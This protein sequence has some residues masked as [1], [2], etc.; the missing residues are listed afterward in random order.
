[1]EYFDVV[2][3]RRMCRNFKPDPLPEGA[4]EKILDA[5]H[6]A[7]SGANGQPWEFVVI[8]KKETKDKIAD[9]YVEVG[10]KSGCVFESTRSEE[11]QHNMFKKYYPNAAGWKVAPVIIAVCGDMRTFLATVASAYYLNGDGGT[12]ATYLMNVANATHLICQSAYALGLGASWVSTESGWERKAKEIL[13]IPNELTIH[14]FVPIGYP[15]SEPAPRYRRELKELIHYEEYDQ[16]RVR[17]D[18]DI[19]E[20][21]RNLR[22]KTRPAYSD[23]WVK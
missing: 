9:L 17:T 3:G 16:S 5:A 7:P 15:V 18:E 22:K 1:M 23:Y 20:F 8:T 13:K 10:R 2:K 19:L 12:F 11:F 4:V 14:Q 21:V 6:Y